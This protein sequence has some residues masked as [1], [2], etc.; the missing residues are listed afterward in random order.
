MALILSRLGLKAKHGKILVN[1]NKRGIKNGEFC[2]SRYAD[3]GIR[4]S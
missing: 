4:S 2:K 1:L 3:Y